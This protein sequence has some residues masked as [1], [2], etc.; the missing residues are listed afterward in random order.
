MKIIYLCKINFREI[1]NFGLAIAGSVFTILSII[2]SFVSWDDMGISSLAIKILIFWGVIFISGA[3]AMLT[4][5]YLRTCNTIYEVGTGKIV[6]RYG[7]LMKLAFP[8]RSKKNKIVVIPVNTSF[9]TIVDK[10]IAEHE[11]SIVSPKTIHGMWIEN[12]IKEGID[13]EQLDS[14]I[15]RQ[16]QNQ[17]IIHTLTRQEKKRG[18]LNC[19]EIGTIISIAGKKNIT[20]FLVAL[21]EFNKNNNAQ[22]NKN[23]VIKC[24]GAVLDYYDMHGQGFELYLPLLGTGLSRAGLLHEESLKI[25]EAVLQLNNEKIHGNINIVIYNKDKTKVSIFK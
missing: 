22:S 21:S 11:K 2:L 4:V 25:I 15:S 14:I 10:N 18:K 9:D 20:F 8:K 7:N 5:C 16:L 17:T 3:V 6:L 24:I 1:K 13:L 12:M 23:E 19:Y